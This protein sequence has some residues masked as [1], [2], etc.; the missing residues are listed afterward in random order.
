MKNR[1]AFNTA[2]QREEKLREREGREE[3][4]NSRKSI[5]DDKKSQSSLLIIFPLRSDYIHSYV[6]RGHKKSAGI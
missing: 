5:Y 2:P 6:G 3:A 1:V 4:I